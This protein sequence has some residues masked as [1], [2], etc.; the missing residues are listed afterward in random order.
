VWQDLAVAPCDADFP[1]PE[2]YRRRIPI[3]ET[4]T[5]MNSAAP[6]PQTPA[7]VRPWRERV[8]N[9]VAQ[10]VEQLARGPFERTRTL[11][12]VG[13]AVQG[14]AF[15]LI[16]R[17]LAAARGLW[18]GDD[19]LSELI[20]AGESGSDRALVER[21]AALDA[22]V[23]AH[24]PWAAGHPWLG[25]EAECPIERW[26]PDAAKTL[27]SAVFSWG[28]GMQP[29]CPSDLSLREVGRLYEALLALHDRYRKTAAQVLL[30]RRKST[31]SYYTPDSIVSHITR[32]SLALLTLER[33]PEEI[34][35]LRVLDPAMGTGHFLLEAL[36]A[37][38]SALA[39][40]ENRAGS[41]TGS[42]A[43][44]PEI[45]PDVRR[46]WLVANSCLYGVDRDA[47]AADVARFLLWAAIGHEGAPPPGLFRHL[48]V[49]NALV[50]SDVED[51]SDLP[52]GERMV[53]LGCRVRA[54]L[55][56]APLESL[57]APARR[58][59]AQVRASCDLRTSLWF[60]PRPA[61]AE[62]KALFDRARKL[63]REHQFL[64]WDL[65]FP[66]V[67]CGPDGQRREDG[68]FDAVIGNPPY[69]AQIRP[70]RAVLRK[71]RYTTTV[72]SDDRPASLNTAAVF[73]DR[74]HQMLRTGGV[75]GLIV[76][77]SLLRVGQYAQVRMLLLREYALH[78]VVDEGAPFDAAN[79]E[80]VSFI[81]VRR[82]APD[83]HRVRIRD[84]RGAEERIDGHVEQRAFAERGVIALYLDDIVLRMEQ[85]RERLG[86]V[87][88]NQRGIGIS[89][90]DLIA[91]SQN[92]KVGR[93]MLRGR[94]LS[95]Y[96]LI[97]LPGEDRYLRRLPP[98][99]HAGIVP[100]FDAEKLLLQN[101]GSQVVAALSTDGE[102]FLETVNV[103]SPLPDCPYS[104]PALLV[105]LNSR[106]MSYYF[107]RALINRSPLTVHLD[108]IYT[109]A[110]PLPECSR[111]LPDRALACRIAEALEKPELAD[112]PARFLLEEVGRGLADCGRQWSAALARSTEALL[113]DIGWG[114]PEDAADLVR[115]NLW[116]LPTEEFMEELSRRNPAVRRWPQPKREAVSELHRW[117]A[118]ELS[119]IGSAMGRAPFPYVGSWDAR[120][121]ELVYCLYGL[122]PEQIARV[123]S[124][125]GA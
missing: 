41:A 104:L 5:F 31:G 93:W 25:A 113:G 42:S 38:S 36:D 56:H 59:H 43:M 30:G 44:P 94:N 72:K 29:R 74:A 65:A 19:A 39:D 98:E 85:A 73:I 45:A 117:A 58:D 34:L 114:T 55:L 16:G 116:T 53:P 63:A 21:L 119:R 61:S 51:L 70:F 48:R 87:V 109:D 12:Q 1:L 54:S 26:Q 107:Q 17:S 67:F 84:H 92:P 96:A 15:R 118:A 11:S 106:L 86:N 103:L 13:H 8:T 115:R 46:R 62:V 78:E 90:S 99:N 112:A 91:L 57:D 33:G 66:E 9:A 121:D 75:L 35:S 27:V 47:N 122:T 80:M 52:G 18:P 89:P 71:G 69:A 20:R 14:V 64:H 97:H 7:W 68:G 23:C 102:G 88:R 2:R 101:I 60:E 81:A 50:G 77:N 6:P 82:H 3:V 100:L 28:D 76:P 105:L 24:A 95:R 110:F 10:A 49:G 123:E 124:A 37:L 40:A 22:E 83:E 108:G 32:Q 111:R 120:A 79:L 4:T 125:M